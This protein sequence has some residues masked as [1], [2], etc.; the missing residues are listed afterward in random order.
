[1]VGRCLFCRKARGALAIFYLR[2]M[3][4]YNSP[5]TI[6][7]RGVC[8]RGTVSRGNALSNKT[9]GDSP[10]SREVNE[11]RPAV[12]FRMGLTGNTNGVIVELVQSFPHTRIALGGFSA[13]T[14]R[15]ARSGPNLARPASPLPPLPSAPP[16]RCN[17]PSAS[18]HKRQFMLVT[19][20]QSRFCISGI[21]RE[22]Q[23]CASHKNRISLARPFC[24]I[25]AAFMGKS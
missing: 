6:L 14:S 24:V 10:A 4:G 7:L 19:T 16:F 2:L 22:L 5:L 8:F 11:G 23:F 3:S 1:M 20:R 18:G 21:I 13:F 25:M 9:T 15:A 17:C 12:A